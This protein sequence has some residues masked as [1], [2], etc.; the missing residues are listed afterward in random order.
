MKTETRNTSHMASGKED[1]PR[2]NHESCSM[3][4]EPALP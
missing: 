1:L 2:H 4:L 3:N